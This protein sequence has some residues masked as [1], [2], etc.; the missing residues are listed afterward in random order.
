VRRGGHRQRVSPFGAGMIAVVII[1]LAVYAAFI[2]KYPWQNP[3]ELKAVFANAN[4]LAVNSPVREA[5]VLVGKVT[6]I[7]TKQGSSASVVTMAL[8]DNGLP[9]HRDAELKIRPRIFLEGNFFVDLKPGS[10]SAKQLASSEPIPISQTYSPVQ[11]D[12]VLG[13]LQEPTRVNT[14]RLLKGYGDAL[15]GKPLPGEDK[16]ADPSTVGQTAAQSLNDSLNTA[17]PALRDLSVVNYA[18]LGTQPH[19]LS[20]LISSTADVSTEL[21]KHEESLKNLVT[22]FNTTMAAFASQAT[23]LRSTIHVLPDV[24]AHADSALL[25]LNNSFPSLRAFSREILPGVR[26]TPTTV[27]ASFPWIAQTRA[28]VSPAEL[29]GLVKDLRPAIGNLANVTDE[30]V[31]LFPQVDLV[32]Q[33]FTNVLLP[34]G[35][36][37]IADPPLSTGIE[38]YKEFWQTMTA[39]SGE[40][41]NFDGNG[42]YTRFQTGGGSQ[43]ISTG[44]VGGAAG[45]QQFGNTIAKPLGSRPARPAVRPPYNRTFPCYKNPIPNL[46]SAETA[47]P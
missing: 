24:L 18:F 41:Q 8:D 9:I 16:L 22:G 14:Q 29:Q 42:Q 47:L 40:S 32:S 12:Q 23:A 7:E 20:Q 13:V 30:S 5:G 46:A 11:I 3:Y 44:T 27:A 35:D 38:N 25:H 1:A 2:H 26:E 17:V 31:K 33:C 6:K 45:S 4:N 43:S 39:L 19:D 37:K 21:A 15:N 36:L 10:P 28:L 34:T